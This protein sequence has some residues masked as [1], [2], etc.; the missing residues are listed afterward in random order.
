MQD[1]IEGFQA[2]IDYIEHNLAKE[3]D[4][5]EISKKASLSSFYYKRD[6]V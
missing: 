2:S 3:L 1:W 6:C 4:I 5:E